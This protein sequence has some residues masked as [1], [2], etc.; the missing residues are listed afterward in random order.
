MASPVSEQTILV[1]ITIGRCLTNLNL[2][3]EFIPVIYLEN[4]FRGLILGKG[5]LSERYAIST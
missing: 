4:L 5:L 1:K 2:T 3:L